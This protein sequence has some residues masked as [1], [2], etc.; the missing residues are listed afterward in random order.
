MKAKASLNLNRMEN[1]FLMQGDI[2]ANL[3][4]DEKNL[5]IKSKFG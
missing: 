1:I 2:Y 5:N 4:F 3:I